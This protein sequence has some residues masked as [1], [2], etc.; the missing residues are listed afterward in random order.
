LF[1]ALSIVTGAITLLTFGFLTALA[2]PNVEANLPTPWA[3]LY[4]RINIAVFLL[5]TVALAVVLLRAPSASAGNTDR[6]S[7]L[8]SR[9]DQW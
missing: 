4:E 8:V 6:I 2:A 1:I 7:V 3:G 5:W 9:N